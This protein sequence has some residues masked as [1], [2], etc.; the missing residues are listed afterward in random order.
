[1]YSGP[2]REALD[3]FSAQGYECPQSYNPAEFLADLISI[4]TS[5]PDAEQDS[6]CS[7]PR[8]LGSEPQI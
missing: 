6:R 8:V 3:F 1:M 4:D 2:A 7:L 5:S